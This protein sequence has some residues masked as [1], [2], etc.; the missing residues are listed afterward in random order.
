M[1]KLY[2]VISRIPYEGSHLLQICDTLDSVKKYLH[3]IVDDCEWYRDKLFVIDANSSINKELEDMDL[4][5][6]DK[7][8]QYHH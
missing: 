3:Q 5:A 7:F 8:L 4:Q 2:I 1:D 6:I